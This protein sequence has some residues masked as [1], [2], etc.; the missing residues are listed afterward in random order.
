MRFLDT[1]VLLRYLTRDD[2]PKARRALALMVRLERNEERAL[3]S[4][5]VVFET[6]FTLEKSYRVP[7]ARIR[8]L[9]EN[10]LSFRGLALA[11][12]R[13]YYEALD[14]YE[15]TAVSFADAYN[16]AF[17]KARGVDEIYS[18]DADFDRVE[19]VVRLEPP[20]EAE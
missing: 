10:L 16:A 17:M 19:G 1:N 12:K 18:W 13:V 8:E 15:R 9:L 20:D 4:P 3:L 11:G 7:R 6:V 14:L 2:E 5:M